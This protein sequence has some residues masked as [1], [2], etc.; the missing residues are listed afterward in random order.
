MRWLIRTVYLVTILAYDGDREEL[1]EKCLFFASTYI[2]LV[3]PFLNFSQYTDDQTSN[4]T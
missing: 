4:T 1:E 3:S 2:R